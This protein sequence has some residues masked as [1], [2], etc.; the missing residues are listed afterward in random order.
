[1]AE[2]RPAGEQL[3]FLSANTGE[4]VLDTY[5]EAAE[6]GGR[7]LS[8]L[9]DDLF[10]PATVVHSVQKILSLDTTQQQATY[11]LEQ[12]CSQTQVQAS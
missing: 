1:M 12:A 9:L 3:R 7:A 4:H 2:T 11:N 5:M 8:D 6:I 10:D